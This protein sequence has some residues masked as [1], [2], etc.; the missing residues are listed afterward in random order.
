MNSFHSSLLGKQRRASMQLLHVRV[1]WKPS[2]ACTL[3][4]WH[5][6][7][8]LA[9]VFAPPF[10]KCG[11]DGKGAEQKLLQVIAQSWP[12]LQAALPK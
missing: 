10:Y 5:Q 6:T 3:L 2:W 11:C 4:G 9:K 12:V 1:L 7:L 8:P